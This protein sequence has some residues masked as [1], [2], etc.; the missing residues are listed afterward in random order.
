MTKYKDLVENKTAGRFSPDE[1]AIKRYGQKERI[2][3]KGEKAKNTPLADFIA[4]IY[5]FGEDITKE[6]YLSK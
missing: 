1:E 6:E 4:K 3:E 5:R 2:I